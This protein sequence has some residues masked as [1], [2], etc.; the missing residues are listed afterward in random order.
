MLGRTEKLR[1]AVPGVSIGHYKV[2]AGTFGAVV[3][4]RKTDELLILSNNHVLAN[5]TDGHDGKSKVGDPVYQP[6]SYDGGSG[7]DLIGHLVRYVPFS[8]YNK[9]VDCKIASMGVKAANAVI[10]TVRPSY[11][12]RLETLGHTNL[13][14]CALAR[15]AKPEL[16]SPEILE[17]GRGQR[18]RGDCSGYSGQEERAHLR[19]DH[20]YG[21]GGQGLS[22]REYGSRQ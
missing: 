13:V 19:P 4:D 17:I 21:Q 6:G 1:P 2:T 20:W 22:E 16:I 15:P 7:D 12:L 9:D 18:H 14:D 5:A 3:K 10:K 11:N 8:R